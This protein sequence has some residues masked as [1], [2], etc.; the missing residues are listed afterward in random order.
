[1]TKALF[2]HR[3]AS[4][5]FFVFRIMENVFGD[6][7]ATRRMD[8]SHI[9]S[10]NHALG[11]ILRE[12]YVTDTSSAA[13]KLIQQEIANLVS[14]AHS[15]VDQNVWERGSDV[16]VVDGS[17]P[18]VAE[19]NLF[20]LTRSF[21]AYITTTAFMG[22]SF[23]EFYPGLLQDMWTF[24]KAFSLLIAG[25]PKWLPM[26]SVSA[27]YGA[28]DRLHKLVTAL[29]MAFAAVED[30]RDPGV[31]LRDLDDLSEMIKQRMRTWRKAGY[32]PSV[33][34]KGDLAV[35]WA[36]NVN[37]SS[38]VFWI[39]LHIYSDPSLH[40]AL[41]EE[42]APFVKASRLTPKETGLPFAEPPR[43]SL[44]LEGLLT[45]CPLLRATFYEAIRMYTNSASYRE[46]SSDLTLTESAEDAAIF[47]AAQPRSYHFRKGDILVVPNGA[48]QMDPRYH[49]NP[50]KFD[51]H[52]FIVKDPETGKVSTEMGTIR[53]FGGG[54]SMCKGRVFAEREILAFTAAILALWDVKPV[55]PKGWK[56]P[57][58]KP[59][60]ATY[61][62]VGDVRVRMKHR[63]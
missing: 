19:A 33:A 22:T 17:D 55:S 45:S 54:A 10:L 34:A 49:K 52:R 3:G 1:M 35:L 46:L 37:S 2:A 63:V 36:M 20:A 53:P 8:K 57:G 47:G 62:P 28:R 31:M 42:M 30:G 6:G 58:L 21:I 4:T 61:I 39:L 7:G 41:E 9:K 38:I 12:P 23:V 56:R 26:P 59:G 5:D 14:F 44:N 11:L 51:P 16:S 13:V 24:D 18:P 29:H 50:D 40:A 32:S 60:S 27:A 48:H 43:L 25:A 15:V